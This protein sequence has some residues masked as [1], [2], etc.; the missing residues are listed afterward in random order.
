MPALPGSQRPGVLQEAG[1]DV[2]VLEA[3]DGVGGRVRTDVVDG[4]QLDRGFQ[5]LLTEYPELHVQFDVEALD[6]R[7][8]EPGALV[9]TGR[10]MHLVGDPIRRP[11]GLFKTAVAPVGSIGDKLR[12]VRQRARLQRASPRD[13]LRQADTDTLSSLK[14]EGFS[15]RMIQQF[16]RPF[17]GGIQLDPSLRTSRRMFDVI[18]RCLLRGDAVVPAAGMGAIPEQLAGRLRQARFTSTPRSRR[19][20]PDRWP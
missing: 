15:D 16:F 7:A 13:L 11:K 12:L 17:V 2:V 14:D 5:V 4:H 10:R 1:R 9:W 18:L 6:L 19:S 8:F 20:P 3:S